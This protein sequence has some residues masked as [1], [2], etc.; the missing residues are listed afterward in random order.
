MTKGMM[1]DGDFV[2][3]DGAY[4]AYE[5]HCVPQRVIGATSAVIGRASARHGECNEPHG[6]A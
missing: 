3:N 1:N 6:E 4:G 5:R 2:A